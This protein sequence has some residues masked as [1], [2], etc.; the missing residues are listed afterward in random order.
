MAGFLP[1]RACVTRD[2]LLDRRISE[3]GLSIEGSPVE[4]L[5]QRLYEELD[6]RGLAFHPPVYLSDEWGCPEA[7][8]LIGVPFYLADPEL[9]RVE[10]EAAAGVEDEAE[11][12]RYM[13]HEAGH[14]INYAYRLY[15]REDWRRIFGPYSR[16]YR[17]RYHVDPFSR[18]FVRHVLGWY[19]QKHPDEDF[20]ETF[21]VWLTPDLDWRAQY[22]GWPAL[23]KLE[24]VDALMQEIATTDP[25]IAPVPSPEHLPVSAMRLTVAEHYRSI[26][27]N[28]PIDDER[29]FD[30]DLRTI[31]GATDAPERA[32]EFIRRHSREL[33]GRIG[34]W[35]GEGPAMVRAFLEHLAK[36]ADALG[37]VVIGLEAST[38][39]ELTA[40]GTAVMMNFRYTDQLDH[41]REPS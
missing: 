31:F 8:P 30:G 26:A 12:M 21:A 5:V 24:Y 32:G 29:V 25:P 1:P 39:I 28:L 33:V 37:L 3:L 41:R 18:D 9:S 7:T 2:D 20:A 34:Y 4:R 13:R 22:D 15:D 17:D 40:F 16:P 19:A 14:A 6:A 36:R 23:R 38:L 10:A 27:A 11:A 35:T